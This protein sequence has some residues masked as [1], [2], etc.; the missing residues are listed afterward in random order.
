MVCT[1]LRMEAHGRV[2]GAHRT[3]EQAKFR[4]EQKAVNT[5]KGELIPE[6]H[7]ITSSPEWTVISLG[8][9]L[10]S[11]SR[12]SW[13]AGGTGMKTWMDMEI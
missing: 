3:V 8:P 11:T 2:G 4:A 5:E 6:L 9:G 7:S 13:W 12:R 10:V 1:G